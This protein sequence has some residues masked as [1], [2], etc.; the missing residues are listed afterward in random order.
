MEA[1]VEIMLQAC[2]VTLAKGL[3][4]EPTKILRWMAQMESLLQIQ[5][6]SSKNF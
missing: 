2:L 3:H 5:V 4:L 6:I 1:L